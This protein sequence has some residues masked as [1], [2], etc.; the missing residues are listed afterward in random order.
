MDRWE[1]LNR[2]QF[3]VRSQLNVFLFALTLIVSGQTLQNLFDYPC[4]SQAHKYSKSATATVIPS[5]CGNQFIRVLT[6]L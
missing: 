4:S 3:I 2:I 6:I 1:R 5:V